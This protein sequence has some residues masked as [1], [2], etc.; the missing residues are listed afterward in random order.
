[1]SDLNYWRPLRNALRIFSADNSPRQLAAGVALGMLIGVLPK[2][3]L[4][5]AS[6]GI[7]LF[8]S[9]ANLGSG[10]TTAFF[11]SL[12]G[13]H[14]DPLTH[15]VGV[16]LLRTPAVYW[17]V[18]RAYQWPLVPWTSLN[19]SVV[20]GSLTLGA[21]LLFP[22]YHVSHGVADWLAAALARRRGRRHRAPVPAAVE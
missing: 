14:L 4:L 6:A 9:R 8:T 3:N 10:L 22:T 20:L 2:G 21:V 19:N 12:F 17:L 7:L 15:G 18:A 5:A 16:R 13:T 11:V 1:M